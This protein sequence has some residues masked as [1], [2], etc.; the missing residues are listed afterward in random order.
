MIRTV[1][2]GK[3]DAQ[4]YTNENSLYKLM[5]TKPDMVSKKLTYHLGNDSSKFPLTF[6]TQAQGKTAMHET[7]DVEYT[8]PVMGRLVFTESVSYN[9]YTA[10]TEKPGLGHAPFEIYFKTNR[11][12]VT[13]GVT[14]RDGSRARIMT[15]G[16]FVEGR[17]YKYLAQMKTTD[18]TAYC[19]LTNLAAG[20]VVA[21]TA[22][23]TS[24]SLSRGNKSVVQGPGKLANQISFNRYTKAIAGNLANKVTEIEFETKSGG[25][26]TRWINEEMRQFEITMRQLNEEHH[27]ESEYN[28]RADGSL[29]MR[30]YD[31]D[32]LVPEGAGVI[33]QVKESNYD[34]YGYN[35]TYGKIKNTIGDVT[36][37]DPDT[38]NMEIVL[39]GGRGFLDDFDIAMKQDA[40]DNGWALA[41]GD[42]IVDSKNGGLAYGKYFTQY[43]DITGNTITAKLVNLFDHGSIAEAQRANGDLHPRTGRPIYSHTGLFLDQSLYGGERNV[44][45]VNQKGQKEITGVYKG[46]APIP[47]SWASAV[48]NFISTDE[49]KSTYEKK[50]SSGIGIR[51]IKHCFMLQ[52]SL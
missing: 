29:V 22:P 5:L 13:Y 47:E 48:G 21:M 51:V 7:N 27:W 24:E 37:G 41:V 14:F 28:R 17:G 23:T 16:E 32:E 2:E 10:G 6:M 38:G 39:Y 30:D 26:T 40:S 44:L 35:L 3:F 31:S 9:Q 25:T 52:A 49:D 18:P 46:M 50:Y 20:T 1:N 42:Q 11:I 34:T 12:P 15:K 8:L 19:A 43:R 4:A 45:Y 36:D 33:Q